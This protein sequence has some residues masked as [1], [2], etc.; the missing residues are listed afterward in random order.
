MYTH[1]IASLQDEPVKLA[2]AAALLRSGVDSSAYTP[3]RP[4]SRAISDPHKME[5]SWTQAQ[6]PAEAAAHSLGV[7]LPSR[8]SLVQWQ[9]SAPYLFPSHVYLEATES[10]LHASTQACVSYECRTNPFYYKQGSF[11]E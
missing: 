1:I 9:A 5:R 8:V 2:T 6:T 10:S 4:L 7:F 11:L 3:G